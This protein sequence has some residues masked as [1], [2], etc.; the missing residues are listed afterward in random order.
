MKG[1]LEHLVDA[2]EELADSLTAGRPGFAR[3]LEVPPPPVYT[4]QKIVR[5]RKKLGTSQTVFA[6]LIGASPAAVRAWE[7]GAKRPSGL[8]RRMLQL[9]NQ[10]PQWFTSLVTERRSRASARRG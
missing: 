1:I 7:R 2:A 3:T 8:A 4:G 6:R 10:Q 9:V 5:I